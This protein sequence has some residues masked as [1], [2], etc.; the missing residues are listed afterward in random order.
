MSDT[1]SNMRLNLN[2]RFPRQ[3]KNFQKGVQTGKCVKTGVSIILVGLCIVVLLALIVYFL[4][5]IAESSGSSADSSMVGA[6]ASYA[7]ALRHQAC[8]QKGGCTL[9]CPFVSADDPRVLIRQQLKSIESIRDAVLEELPTDVD[10]QTE[11]AK[12]DEKNQPAAI[13]QLAACQTVKEET[14]RQIEN[15]LSKVRDIDHIY[16]RSKSITT[17]VV[18]AKNR[19]SGLDAA[20]A[21][22]LYLF[23]AAVV[24]STAQIMLSRMLMP[25]NV[26]AADK[27][28]DALIQDSIKRRSDMEKF[29]AELIKRVNGLNPAVSRISSDD[30]GAGDIIQTMSELVQNKEEIIEAMPDYTSNF[31]PVFASYQTICFKPESFSNDLPAKTTTAKVSALIGANDYTSATM[32][33]ALEPEI[34]TNH[35]KF[36]KERSSFDSGGGVPSVRDDDNDVVKWVGIF[37]RPTYRRSDGTSADTGGEPLRSIPSD[38]PADMMR[39]SSPKFT[40]A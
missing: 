15:I 31:N 34:I 17:A 8:K 35:A 13:S 5:S 7:L 3:G 24:E 33:T 38:V 28:Y 20:V 40:L 14:Y 19:V 4:S 37:G 6:A 25:S 27:N 1:T 21:A 10:I 23:T 11:I 30:S 26:G 9:D 29:Y 22:N 36:A 39:K 2:D 12:L 18:R 32:L 16:S